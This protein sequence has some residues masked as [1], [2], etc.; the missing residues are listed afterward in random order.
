MVE[1]TVAADFSAYQLDFEPVLGRPMAPG[2][3][4]HIMKASD[5]PFR[6][7]LGDLLTDHDI[8]AFEGRTVRP[9]SVVGT[10]EEILYCC[11]ARGRFILWRPLQR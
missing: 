2:I 4:F 7:T 10:W 5:L 9:D 8:V 1:G 3:A 6:L 11:G